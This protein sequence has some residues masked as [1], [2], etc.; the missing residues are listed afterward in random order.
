MYSELGTAPITTLACKAIRFALM[1]G[2]TIY[3]ILFN[4]AVAMTGG[5]NCEQTG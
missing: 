5:Q 3:K 4:D 2:T 1:A